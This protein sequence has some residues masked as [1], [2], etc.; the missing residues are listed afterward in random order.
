M[1]S[2]K[3][4]FSVLPIKLPVRFFFLGYARHAAIKLMLFF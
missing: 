1:L 4:E 3:M 2:I